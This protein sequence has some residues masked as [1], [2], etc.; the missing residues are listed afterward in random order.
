MHQQRIRKLLFSSQLTFLVG[1][2]PEI[3]DRG[4]TEFMMHYKNLCEWMLEWPGRPS[5]ELMIFVWVSICARCPWY[6]S[7]PRLAHWFTCRYRFRRDCLTC[8]CHC[9]FIGNLCWRRWRS[10][11]DYRSWND[12]ECNWNLSSRHSRCALVTETYSCLLECFL[13]RSSQ[14]QSALLLLS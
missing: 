4:R 9:C 10:C 5:N 12:E 7:N 2:W 3:I 8:S 6:W 11:L 1:R 14:M 13:S